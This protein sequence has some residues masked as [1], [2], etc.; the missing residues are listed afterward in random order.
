MTHPGTSIRGF[1]EKEVPLFSTEISEVRGLHGEC[2][3][4]TKAYL[5]C[6]TREPASE[7]RGTKCQQASLLDGQ[8]AIAVRGALNP[9]KEHP[10]LHVSS[11]P[12]PKPQASANTGE[13]GCRT[14]PLHWKTLIIVNT[15]C[16]L[17]KTLCTN[18]DIFTV[19]IKLHS[20]AL[21]VGGGT[22]NNVSKILGGKTE[23][24]LFVCFWLESIQGLAFII[25]WLS[26]VKAPRREGIW[27]E[28]NKTLKPVSRR[29]VEEISSNRTDSIWY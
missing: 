2:A 19:K 25:I 5:K 21:P 17:K 14:L 13:R 15:E 27:R 23:Y 12:S 8:E 22:E 11:R 26:Y 7:T 4:G 29:S 1:E 28:Q 3:L 18:W 16:V 10:V 24:Y 6:Y 9:H 20:S